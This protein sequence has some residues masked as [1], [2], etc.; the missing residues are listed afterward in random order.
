MIFRMRFHGI[1]A[2]WCALLAASL[3]FLQG[4]GEKKPTFSTEYQ[5]VFMD[6]GQIFFGK[7]EGAGSPYPLL[8]EVYYIGKQA[9][10]DGKEVKT[11]LIKRGNEWHSPDSMYLNSRHIVIIESVGAG[12]RVAQ[13]IKEA[14]NQQPQPSQQQ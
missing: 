2:V 10:P 3:L 9:S 14:K 4:C 1:P 12:S 5:A 11:M 8:K 7:M 13:L 6:N